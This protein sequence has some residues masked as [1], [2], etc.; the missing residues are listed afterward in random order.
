MLWTKQGHRHNLNVAVVDKPTYRRSGTTSAV[1]A[2]IGLIVYLTVITAEGN[3]D[4]VIVSLFAVVMA[5]GGATAALGSRS[6]D[7]RVAQRWLRVAA[8]LLGVI[9]VLGLFSI[10]IFFIAAAGFAMRASAL[11]TA[12]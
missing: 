3:N 10:G 1:V 12:G 8:V 5:S 6:T 11:A 2:L 9:G 7:N 4:L